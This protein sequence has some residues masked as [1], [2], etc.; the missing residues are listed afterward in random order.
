ML[1]WDSAEFRKSVDRV[2]KA[3]DGPLREHLA[4][5]KQHIQSTRE[6]HD[7][8]RTRSQE[9]GESIVASILQKHRP[10]LLPSLSES[11]HTQLLDYYSAILSVRDREEITRVLCRQSPDLFTQA[12]RDGVAAF[13]PIIRTIHQNVDIREHLSAMETFLNDFIKTSR[14]SKDSS[15]RSKKTDSVPQPPSVEDYVR[16]LQRNESLLYNWLHEFTANCP[17]VRESFRTWAKDVIRTFRQEQVSAR[18]ESGNPK[19]D[20][21][22]S[23]PELR[24]SA[25]GAMSSALQGLYAGLPAHTQQEV[26][27]TLDS[28]A[29][30]LTDLERLSTSRLQTVIDNLANSEPPSKSGAN[31]P[32]RTGVSAPTSGVSTPTKA[33]SMAGPGMYLSRWQ[34]LLNQTVVTPA[35]V[36]G[37]LRSGKDIKGNTTMG[38]TGSE[39]SKDAWDSGFL[40]LQ[41][42]K[43]VPAPPNVDPA[44][45][46]FLPGFRR[47]LADQD[48]KAK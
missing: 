39:G 14:P 15:S 7:A 40:A 4:A 21:A 6:D 17:E 19:A 24:Q 5:I 42:E 32:K 45:E 28:Y 35:S 48:G 44:L 9:K 30:Y 31:T 8:V 36:K 43:D 29:T 12:L 25:A 1:S 26:L 47:I 46:A 20:D 41:A 23:N 22:T 33:A 10:D 3:K 27:S 13:D 38:K 16:L 11:D 34:A 37:P 2:E 18:T